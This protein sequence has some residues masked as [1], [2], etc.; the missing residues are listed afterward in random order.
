MQSGPERPIPAAR[1]DFVEALVADLRAV[2]PAPALRRVLLT[3]IGFSV[4]ATGAVTLLLGP[5]RDDVLTDLA[6]PR[7]A[8]EI[9]LGFA[10]LIALAV[11][12]L[13]AGVPGGPRRT[14]LVLPPALFAIGWLAIALGA[15][16]L[17]GPDPSSIGKRE[18][19][20]LEGLLLILAPAVLGLRSI[21]VRSLGAGWLSGGL[22]GLAAGGLP[23]L[24]MQLA[25]M[26]DPEHALHFH[27]TPMLVAAALS[28]FGGALLERQT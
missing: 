13:E 5:L 4:L 12:G 11:A 25:C 21:R 10:T 2:T 18:H 1:L 16:S 9:G 20:F 23:A 6:T 22:I 8:L 28:A 7:L 3:W 24:A 27:F 26:Y 19:C 15:F 14:L 17:A